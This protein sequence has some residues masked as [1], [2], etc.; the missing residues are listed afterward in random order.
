MKVINMVI[1]NVIKIENVYMLHTRLQY[2]IF[3]DCW[4]LNI[5]KQ[6][7]LLADGKKS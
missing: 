7:F 3:G 1:D 2:L 4:D 5:M 6:K